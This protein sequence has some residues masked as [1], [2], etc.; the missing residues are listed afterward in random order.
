MTTTNLRRLIASAATAAVLFAASV[1]AQEAAS[2]AEGPSPVFEIRNYHFEPS[3]MG[4]YEA[5]SRDY[6]LPY[7]RKNLDVVG[8]WISA[9][10]DPE[11]EGEPLD[12]LG[13][14]TV[15]WIIRWNSKA[16]RDQRMEKV[17]SG[18][19]WEAIFAKVPGG[20]KSYLRIEAK[21]FKE[22]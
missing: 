4:Q 7:L 21:F 16:E 11:L 12:Q 14:A 22:L 8:F 5:W 2:S 1:C 19:E 15:T 10:I 3:L 9:G 6:A 17:F 20:E 18:S 13:S